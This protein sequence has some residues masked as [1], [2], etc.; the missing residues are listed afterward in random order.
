M[1][2]LVS[3]LVTSG[4]VAASLMAVA[5]S[6]FAARK[7]D[8]IREW[9]PPVAAELAQA[10]ARVEPGAHAEYLLFEEFIE[11]GMQATAR[12]VHVRLKVFDAAGAQAC[13]TFQV[14][15]PEKYGS[16]EELAGRTV[17]PDGT[18]YEMPRGSWHDQ[19]VSRRGKKVMRRVTFSLPAVSPGAILEYRYRVELTEHWSNRAV[20]TFRLD[21]PAQRIGYYFRPLHIEQLPAQVRPRPRMIEFH[22]PAKASDRPVNGWN[23]FEATDQPAAFEEPDMPPR[24]Q[25]AG[26]VMLYYMPGAATSGERYWKQVATAMAD[27]FDD[28]TS[29]DGDARRLA[30]SIC[31]GAADDFERAMRLGRW[32][33]EQ[34]RVV[35]SSEPDS[36]RAAWLRDVDQG[37]EALRQRGGSEEAAQLALATLAR[38]AGLRARQLLVGD[39]KDFY[40]DPAMQDSGSL[41]ERRV[42]LMTEGSWYVM[43]GA[44]Q[45][46]DG[47]MMRE[48]EEG[49]IGFVCDRDSFGFVRLPIAGHDRSRFDRVATLAL[50]DEG[51]LRGDVRL[52]ATGHLADVMQRRYAGVTGSSLDSLLRREVQGRSEDLALRS[53]TLEPGARGAGRYALGA[54]AD[55]PMVATSAGDRLVLQPIV[56]QARRP[57]R[58]TAAARRGSVE[59]PYAWTETDSVR[60]RLPE[61]W[62]LDA[63]PSPRPLVAPGLAEYS[64]SATLEDDGR[65]LVAVRRLAIGIEGVLSV[66]RDDYEGLKKLFDRIAE[67]DRLSVTL[68]RR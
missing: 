60:I 57:P 24:H 3:L 56:F 21:W 9:E 18:V 52:S 20:L 49:Q 51:A 15:Y 68:V 47:D 28:A 54:K 40:F 22:S 2:R 43:D 26:W 27:R 17:L 33:R 66:S 62:K 11:D 25:E 5:A 39:G 32:M 48:R 65:T 16:L 7:L 37:R 8:P 55:W 10:S 50:D 59:F 53:W 12:D 19:P 36:F 14:E 35:E 6:T 34:F 31:A 64:V 58:Y 44:A 38:G 46:L 67:L 1:K 29:P 41:P 42:A 61:G 4:L 63:L 45:F 30:G 13:A 23:A